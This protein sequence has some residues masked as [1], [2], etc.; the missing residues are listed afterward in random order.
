MGVTPYT[1][2]Q[3]LSSGVLLAAG[4]LI[5]LLPGESESELSP[6]LG[7][8]LTHMGPPRGKEKGEASPWAA[9]L[10]TFFVTGLP[11]TGPHSLVYNEGHLLSAYYVPRAC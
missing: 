10:S 4:R 9:Y 7:S 1:H 8:W 11:H 6:S 3:H 2:I 5:K